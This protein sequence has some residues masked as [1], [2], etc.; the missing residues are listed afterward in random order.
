MDKKKARRRNI[1]MDDQIAKDNFYNLYDLF[2]VAH[3]LEQIELVNLEDYWI[4][5]ISQ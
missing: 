3:W 4:K 1:E 5:N 2:P